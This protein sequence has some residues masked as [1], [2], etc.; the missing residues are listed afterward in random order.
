MF[1]GV[2]ILFCNPADVIR[3]RIYNQ[4]FDPVT[5]K[6]TLFYIIKSFF[7][8]V[9]FNCNYNFYKYFLGL[10]YKNGFDAFLKIFKTEGFAGFYKGGWTH[11]SRLGPHIIL[12]FVFLEQMK[13]WTI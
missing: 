5:G 8:Y 13:N 3:T 7:L 6:G 2:S 4:P 1:I 11:Y 10:L 12:V 9:I